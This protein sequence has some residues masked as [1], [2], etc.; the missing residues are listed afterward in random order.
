RTA[1][2]PDRRPVPDPR[3]DQPA[4]RLGDGRGAG[5]RRRRRTGPR[6]RRVELLG[7]G[8]DP[9]P[10]RAASPRGAP[11]VEPDRAVAAAHPAA[12]LRAGRRLPRPRRGADRLLAD[13][14]GPTDRQV[15]GV[16]PAAGATQLLGAS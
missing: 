16:E 1:A 7:P 15:L 12:E 10:L 11:G 8:D 3:P 5:D 6:R 13:R 4:V 14:P 2:D 9:D